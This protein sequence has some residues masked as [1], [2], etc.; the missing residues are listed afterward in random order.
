MGGFR[1]IYEFMRF[2]KMMGESEGAMAFFGVA[3][4]PIRGAKADPSQHQRGL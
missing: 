3:F 1:H 4:A 2:F